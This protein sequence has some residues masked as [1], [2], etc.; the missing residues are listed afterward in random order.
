[1]RKRFITFV[2]TLL[3]IF[4]ITSCCQNSEFIR[5][6]LSEPTPAAS[7]YADNLSVDSSDKL[8][9][10]FIDVGQADCALLLC[11]GESMLIDG[12]NAA[13][14]SLLFSYL[15]KLNVTSIDYMICSH[16]HEDHVGGLSAPLSTMEVKNVF[17]PKKEST[18]KAYNNFKTKAAEQGL[19]II[20]PQSGDTISFG[21]CTVEFFVPAGLGSSNMNNTSIICKI[22]FGNTSFL[23]TGDAEREEEQNIIEQGCN[24]R[25]DVLKVGHHGSETSTSYV[26]LRE[27]MPK[28]SVISVGKKNSYGHPSEAVLSRLSDEGSEVFRTDLNGDIIMESDGTNISITTQKN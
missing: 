3:S 27:V 6:E 25:A 21:G 1:M 17:A 20:H 11:G 8:S 15:K 28:Y 9:V 7:F 22:T 19:E 16:A 24:L 18:S 4:L 5:P 2:I 23:F 12:G 10:H 14:S 13:D 26:F